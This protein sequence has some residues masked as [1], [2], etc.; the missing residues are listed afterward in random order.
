M[1]MSEATQRVAELVEEAADE[2]ELD[3]E[4]SMAVEQ[5]ILSQ[6]DHPLL[7]IAPAVHEADH[8]VEALMDE[9]HNRSLDTLQAH[10]ELKRVAF[11]LVRE[12]AE[13]TSGVDL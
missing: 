12:A 13:D 9:D 4:E 5:H 10:D 6:R 8:G 2:L 3:G 7:Y 11:E 1:N